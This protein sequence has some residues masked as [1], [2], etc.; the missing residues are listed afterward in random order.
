MIHEV[1]NRIHGVQLFQQ[2]VNGCRRTVLIVRLRARIGC[3]RVWSSYLGFQ[4]IAHSRRI[5][6]LV[7]II[8]LERFERFDGD[9]R[10]AL[11]RLLG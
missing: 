3:A 5:R 11:L 7:S 6:F 1:Q 8:F 10:F 9:D 4:I 2:Y